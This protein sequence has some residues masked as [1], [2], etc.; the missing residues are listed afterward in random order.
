MRKGDTGR[1]VQSLVVAVL[2][3][4]GKVVLLAFLVLVL[5]DP[6]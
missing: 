3:V 6:A 2:D 4:V 1:L 5:I